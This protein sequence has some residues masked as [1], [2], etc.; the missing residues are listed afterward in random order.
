LLV[1]ILFLSL[2]HTRTDCSQAQQQYSTPPRYVPAVG[3]SHQVHQT[4]P[5]TR[6]GSPFEGS[7]HFEGSALTESPS[8][9]SSDSTTSPFQIFAVEQAALEERTNLLRA[10]VAALEYAK[11]QLKAQETQMLQNLIALLVTTHTAGRT[12]LANEEASARQELKQKSLTPYDRILRHRRDFAQSLRA[13][14]P[15]C[16]EFVTFRCPITNRVFNLETGYTDSDTE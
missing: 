1:F 4:A 13:T 12:L 6:K 14:N 7:F 15:C 3:T 9:V 11:K 10:E 2:L 16:D 8:H 5:E